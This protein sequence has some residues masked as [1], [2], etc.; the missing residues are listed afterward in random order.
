MSATTTHTVTMKVPTTTMTLFTVPITMPIQIVGEND[1]VYADD[2]TVYAVDD[3]ACNGEQNQLVSSI[4]WGPM[5]PSYSHLALNCG[6][7]HLF[8]NNLK[9]ASNL[10]LNICIKL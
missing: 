1:D 8:P 2:S 10:K 3:Y 5:R 7:K 6:M 4:R 9:N